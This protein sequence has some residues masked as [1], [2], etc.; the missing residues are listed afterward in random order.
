MEC[1]LCPLPPRWSG[2]DAVSRGCGPFALSALPHLQCDWLRTLG[3]HLFVSRLLLWRTLA[4]GRTLVGSGQRHDRNFP[5]PG[6]SDDLALALDWHPRAG[7][8][9]VVGGTGRPPMDPGF[10]PTF[11][12]ADR[13]EER[14]VG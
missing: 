9:S 1:L 8:S 14:R 6:D 2:I 4:S 7:D 3:R 13:S 10:S 12:L 11:R 5:R